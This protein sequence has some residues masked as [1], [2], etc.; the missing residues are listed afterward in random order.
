MADSHPD[1]HTTTP[2]PLPSA[3]NHPPSKAKLYYDIGMMVVIL[4]DLMLMIIDLVLMSD[5]TLYIAQWLNVTQSL[6][7]YINNIHPT[8]QFLGS[9]FTLFL[10]TEL[11]IRWII[12]IVK[13][14]HLRWFFFPFIHWYEVLGCFPQLRALRL[15]RVIVIIRRMHQL[16]HP[17]LPHSW[18]QHAKFYFDVVLEEIADRVILTATNHIRQ[19]M[20]SDPNN[21]QLISKIIDKNRDA[22]VTTVSSFINQNLTTNQQTTQQLSQTLAYQ[23]GM[24]IQ[25][26]IADTP[27]IHRYI[28]MIPIAGNMIESHIQTVAQHVGENV[29]TT[30]TH[31]LT[32]PQVIESITKSVTHTLTHTEINFSQIEALIILLAEEGLTA[33]EQQVKVQQWKLRDEFKQHVDI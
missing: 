15:L 28:H 29:V 21:Q 2:E 31:R 8:M 13:K 20:Q 22:I 23:V 24:S 32:Q 4:F 18:I 17:V 3:H 12:S 27:E 1:P 10:F 14:E 11:L 6:Q 26:A 7:Y 16:G 33:F 30:L 25:Q 19:Q 5:F 9:F